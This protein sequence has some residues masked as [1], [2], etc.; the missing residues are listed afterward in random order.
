MIAQVVV[1]EIQSLLDE[2]ELSQRRIARRLGVSRGT[3]H[4]IANGK[5]PDYCTLRHDTDGFL[6]PVGPPR[7]CP[8]CGGMVLM[9]C[10]LCHV[11][12]RAGGREGRD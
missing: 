3:V 11:R 4:A 9:P 2:G 6:P 10:L 7:R 12:S 1:D 5:R 8:S